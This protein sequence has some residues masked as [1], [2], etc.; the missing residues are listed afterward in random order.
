MS[1]DKL[2][3]QRLD[4]DWVVTSR[5][6]P[7]S[8]ATGGYFSV[9]FNVKKHGRSA[10]MKAFDLERLFRSGVDTLRMQQ[11]LESINYEKR[12]LEKCKGTTKAV[13]VPIDQGKIQID[14]VNASQPIEYLIFDLA[15]QDV[16]RYHAYLSQIDH[17][18]NLEILQHTA[19]G[20]WELHT[21]QIAHQDLKP[22]NVLLFRADRTSR[23]T[24][25]GRSTEH[26]VPIWHDGLTFA[27]DRSYAPIEVLYRKVSQ[28]WYLRRFAGD[29][30]MLGSFAMF[31]FTSVNLTA[32]IVSRLGPEQR[33]AEWTDPYRQVMPYLR[34]ALR[35]VL[36]EH[37]CFK[38]GTGKEI[39]TIIR[40]LCDP[41]PRLRGSPKVTNIPQRYSLQRYFEMFGRMARQVQ[42]RGITP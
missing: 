38:H 23:V 20:L 14:G 40:E 36:A 3:G 32:Q 39:D 34:V 11:A 28:D 27:G 9:T 5:V 16:R 25:L 31:L 24:D 17:L 30:Y 2:V 19:R 10:F 4:S 35:Q 15:D 8:A 13:M 41:D 7:S 33:P 6:V 1:W 26:G 22:S 37:Q 18:V 12:L 29:L 21:L 42:V